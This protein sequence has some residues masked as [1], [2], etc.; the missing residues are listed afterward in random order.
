MCKYS[1]HCVPHTIDIR[2]QRNCIHNIQLIERS[3][4]WLCSIAICT[5]VCSTVRLF[6]IFLALAR[7]NLACFFSGLA[8]M[9]CARRHNKLTNKLKSHK[10]NGIVVQAGNSADHVENERRERAVKRRTEKRKVKPE[11]EKWYMYRKSR[12]RRPV[13]VCWGFNAQQH[14]ELSLRL[15]RR[16]RPTTSVFDGNVDV[17]IDRT[18][19]ANFFPSIRFYTKRFHA[20]THTHARTQR[21][22]CHKIN[23]ILD[24]SIFTIYSCENHST[25]ITPS[26]WA[27]T[28]LL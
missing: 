20:H 18:R 23:A 3:R 6:T 12:E 21:T 10:P 14:T 4:C 16:R 8:P 19:G 24:D 7:N 17:D 13:S 25:A 2:Q 11:F 27:A 28:R 5:F 15:Q 1:I 26:V 9:Q 22:H